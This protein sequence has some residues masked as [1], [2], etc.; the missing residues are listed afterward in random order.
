ADWLREC[1]IDTLTDGAAMLPNP[2]RVIV[3]LSKPSPT[4]VSGSGKSQ[5]QL[6]PAGHG[7]HIDGKQRVH[8]AGGHKPEQL[9][10]MHGYFRYRVRR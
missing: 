10:V 9:P 4:S 6:D 5:W 2:A 7:Q 8:R 3:E 1:A